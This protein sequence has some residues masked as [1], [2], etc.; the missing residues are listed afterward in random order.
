MI[1]PAVFVWFLFV[2]SY[3]TFCSTLLPFLE[4]HKEHRDEIAPRSERE[5]RNN[6]KETNR[7]ERQRQGARDHR[8]QMW[9]SSQLFIFISLCSLFPRTMVILVLLVCL[10]II[11]GD[12]KKKAAG[13]TQARSLSP[14]SDL[15]HCF[16][17]VLK[18]Q[19]GEAT[20]NHFSV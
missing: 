9:A 2:L 3:A 10:L 20:R 18:N 5:P 13:R 16:F 12:K 14:L 1:S 17:C 4:E 11:L 8:S 19:E 6:N 7:Q 15:F